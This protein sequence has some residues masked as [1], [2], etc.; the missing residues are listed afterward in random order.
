MVAGAL[1]FSKLDL[2]NG[3]NL[4]RIKP[5]DEWKTAFR[6]R[7]GHFEYVVMPFGLINAP[8]SFQAMMNEVLKEFLDKGVVVYM[9]DILIY[10]KTVTEHRLLLS[11]VMARLMEHGLAADIEKCVF[12]A[13]SVEFLGYIISAKGVGMFEEKVKAILEWETPR[14]VKDVRSFLGFANF[15]RR[16]IEG[17]SRL[18]IPL[19]NLT[20]KDAPWQ[21]TEACQKAFDSLKARF[22]SA[23]ILSHFD[24]DLQTILET[25]ASDFAISGILSQFHGKILHPVAYLSHK[26]EKAERNYDIHDKEMF[27]IV[28]SCKTWRHYLEGIKST[29]AIITDHANLQ[30]FMTTKMLNRRQARWMEEMSELNFKIIYP[31]G[32][33]GGKPDA[34]TRRT[35]DRP[36]KEGGEDSKNLVDRVLNADTVH[37][38]PTESDWN[39]LDA[40]KEGRPAM[41]ASVHIARMHTPRFEKEFL[42]SVKSAGQSDEEWKRVFESLSTGEKADGKVELKDEVLWR[43]GL[44]WVPSSEELKKVILEAEHDSKIA[45]HFGRDK[46]YE[47]ITRNFTWPQMKSDIDDYVTTCPTCRRNKASRHKRYGKLSALETPEA[48]W[49]DISMDF[50]TTLPS[51]RG[52]TQ[53]WVIVDRFTKM[54]HF[55]ALP[56]N[57]D[58]GML[59]EIF[60]REIWRLHGLPG[61]IV[62]DRDSK[63]T[64]S[65][66]AEVMRRLG[67]KLRM[68][69]AFHPQTDGQTERLNQTIE[70][71]LRIF[72][73]FEQ[74]DW[75]ELLPMAE[76]T[77]N[78]SVTS[79][80]GLTPFSANYGFNPRSNWPVEVHGKNPAS[81]LYAHWMESVHSHLRENLEETRRRMGKY[82]D[83]KRSEVPS[84]KAGDKVWLDGRYIKSKV[85]SKKLGPKMYGPFELLEMVG[86][87]A[88][89]L[90]LPRTWRC[91]N[92]FNVSLLEPYRRSQKFTRPED[93][94]VVDDVEAERYGDDAGEYEVKAILASTRNNNKQLQYLV[95]WQGYPINEATDRK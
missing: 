74:N 34:L 85:A 18:T 67:I 27:A 29:V 45:G 65:H 57:A 59:V 30:Y 75:V 60:L 16:F 32:S 93:Y 64:S 54:A 95:K 6:C 76:F 4:L 20:R 89:R 23:P 47:R 51:S 5:G 14:T 2:K 41:M 8:A 73:N 37:E 50:I 21:W 39:L 24:P 17:Y 69:T 44:L 10:T 87:N 13:P 15:Y 55:V 94:E 81:R 35:Q 38:T 63:F 25:D 52:M 56:T 26:M 3:Y 43:E 42:E 31:P 61:S 40:V 53:I 84:W 1:I 11:K 28:R 22:T 79:A 19:T 36:P 88:A 12:E 91:H 72:C 58:A 83:Q 62:S 66:W 33:Q 70:V 68:S 86:K 90:K 80:T 78:D 49:S 82:Y 7:Y 71:F 46:T 9:D 92:V 48:P 77:Y